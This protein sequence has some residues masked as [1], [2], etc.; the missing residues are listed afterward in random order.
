VVQ[1]NKHCHEGLNFKEGEEV[2]LSTANL[3]L[4]KGRASKLCP[5]Y[6]GPYKVLKADHK[7]LTYKL[8][9][10][11]DLVKQQIH[12]VFHKNV[13]KRYIRNNDKLFLG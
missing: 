12:D 2:L 6:V 5:K 13:L 8:K 4:P 10:P 7:M 11:P 9:L 3:S 1:A